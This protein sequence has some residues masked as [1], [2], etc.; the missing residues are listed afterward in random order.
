MEVNLQQVHRPVD[1]YLPLLDL[2]SHALLPDTAPTMPEIAN[3]IAPISVP[4]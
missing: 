2:F 3:D 1:N 4:I